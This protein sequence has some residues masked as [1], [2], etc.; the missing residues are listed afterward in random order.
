MSVLV[1]DKVGDKTYE[2]G[3]DRGVLYLSDGKAVP[4]NGLTS[5]V[6]KF[7][8]D[9]SP[10][11]YDGMKITDIISL[12]DFSATLTAITYPDE[13]VELDGYGFLRQGMY[14]GNQLPKTFSLSYR[15]QIGNDVDGHVAGYKIHVVYNLTAIPN[16]RTYDS[17]GADISPIEFE[18]D[19]SSVPQDVPGFRPTS[20]IIFDTIDLE[21]DLLTFI[22]EK[23]YGSENVDP[24]LIS[25]SDLISYMYTWARMEIV[26]N[27]D[28]TW[29]AITQFD[30]DIEFDVLDNKLFTILNANAIYLDSE[31]YQ[32]SNVVGSSDIT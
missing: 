14:V 25:I 20:H 18:W 26:D 15:T 4:W 17:V 24:S 30:E 21:P 1:W 12:G 16:D 6:E 32:I 13:F 29:T 2:T 9:L 8:K 28:G 10:I 19:I 5:I 3:V 7:D 23:L 22:E 27:G 31:T 11:Y